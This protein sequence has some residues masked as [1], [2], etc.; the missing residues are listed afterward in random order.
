MVATVKTR[1]GKALFRAGENSTSAD[2]GSKPASTVSTEA[3]AGG[4]VFARSFSG[5]GLPEIIAKKVYYRGSEAKPRDIFDIAA[6]ARSQLD[7]VV[8]A[9]RALPEQVARTR[10]RMETLNPEFVGRA[11]A[12]LM[13]MPEYE[14]SAADSLDVALAVLDEALSS[15]QRT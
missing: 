2:C 10:Q 11:I 13:I 1:P 12:Q 4:R 5:S 15:P 9:L 14:A 7:E 8:N 6:A 3:E